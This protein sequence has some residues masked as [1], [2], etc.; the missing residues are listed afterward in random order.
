AG[1]ILA[2]RQL[3]TGDG[4]NS[5]NAAPLHFGLKTMD[6]VKVEVTWMSRKGRKI[7]TFSNVKPARFAGKSLIFKEQ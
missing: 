7:Q 4:Y 6:A 5:E 3:S 1:K 2:T